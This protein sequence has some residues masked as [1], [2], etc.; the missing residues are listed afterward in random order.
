MEDGIVM[1]RVHVDDLKISLRSKAQ[2]ETVVKQLKMIYG[3]ITVHYGNENDYL[4]MVLSYHPDQK[5][6][7]L[8]IGKN[9]QP[10]ICFE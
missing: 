4:G 2:L 1:I 5:K 6:I 3:E 9:L 8:K 10:T 7:L